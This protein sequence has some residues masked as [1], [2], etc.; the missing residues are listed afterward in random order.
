MQVASGCL[1]NGI[2]FGP[3]VVQSGWIIAI[4]IRNSLQHHRIFTAQWAFYVQCS[5]PKIFVNCN[6]SLRKFYKKPGKHFGVVNFPTALIKWLRSKKKDK[7][8]ATWNSNYPEI[9]SLWFMIS[10]NG[11]VKCFMALCKLFTDH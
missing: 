5:L 10:F 9:K 2:I 6:K 4:C 11:N 7:T 1:F 3:S 8:I